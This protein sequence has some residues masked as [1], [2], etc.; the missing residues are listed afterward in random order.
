MRFAPFAMMMR[1]QRS[2]LSCAPYHEACDSVVCSPPQPSPDVLETLQRTRDESQAT[3]QR[4]GSMVDRGRRT[5][6]T[7][8]KLLTARL[9][10]VLLFA[11]CSVAQ[12]HPAHGQPVATVC[13]ESPDALSPG[14]DESPRLPLLPDGADLGPDWCLASVVEQAMRVVTFTNQHDADGPRELSI[15]VQQFPS[16]PAAD[17]RIR[18]FAL[19]MALGQPS[20]DIEWV[21]VGDGVAV[22]LTDPRGQVTYAWRVERLALLVVV[23]GATA[24][25]ADLAAFAESVVA[26]QDQRVRGAL[27]IAPRPMIPGSSDDRVRRSEL[28]PGP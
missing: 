28:W 2:D 22:R 9:A 13:P 5:I 8:N 23:T 24:Q 4:E 20:S 27:P 11:V 14:S 15:G 18:A 1:G 26:T 21:E 10:L 12:P 6:V 16:A 19:D 17:A 7:A 25:V 3:L